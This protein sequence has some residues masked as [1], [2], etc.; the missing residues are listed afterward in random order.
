MQRGTI[1]WAVGRTDHSPTEAMWEEIEAELD[2]IRATES[3]GYP[4]TGREFL[5]S[6]P[7][8]KAIMAWKRRHELL[9]TDSM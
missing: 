9:P 8:T 7:A 2:R 5:G 3:P 4:I 6:H 1:M